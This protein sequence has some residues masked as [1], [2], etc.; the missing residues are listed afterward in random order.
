[1]IKE[2]EQHFSQFKMKVKTDLDGKLKLND[3]GDIGFTMDKDMKIVSFNK[4]KL[5]GIQIELID[6]KS[7]NKLLEDEFAELKEMHKDLI[8]KWKEGNDRIAQLEKDKIDLK[9]DYE[10]RF[11]VLTQN[12]NQE[13]LLLRRK[14]NEC[15]TEFEQFK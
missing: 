11:I 15:K 10:Q 6:E 5:L 12:S 4:K 8:E 14:L 2:V 3:F 7:K 13:V 9:A 1:M